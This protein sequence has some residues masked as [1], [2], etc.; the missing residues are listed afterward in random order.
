MS[1]GKWLNK[2]AAMAQMNTSKEVRWR[3]NNKKRITTITLLSRDSGRTNLA[4]SY[5]TISVVSELDELLGT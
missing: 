3:K 2:S 4:E 5:W 1:N